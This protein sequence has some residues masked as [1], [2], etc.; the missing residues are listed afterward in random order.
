M[1][2]HHRGICDCGFCLDLHVSCLLPNWPTTTILTFDSLIL[3]DF[4]H[5]TR[6]LSEEEKAIATY[7]LRDRNGNDDAE[8]G[9][10]LSGVR[11]AVTDYKVWLLAYVPPSLSR[12]SSLLMFNQWHRHHQD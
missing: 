2:V 9:S 12:P 8:R 11:M 3:P 10:L 7:R 5:T 6:W 4:P 1:V